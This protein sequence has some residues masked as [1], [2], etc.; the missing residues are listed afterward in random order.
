M[1]WN[2]TNTDISE[3]QRYE[4][5]TYHI[6]RE[7]RGNPNIM[8]MRQYDLLNKHLKINRNNLIKKHYMDSS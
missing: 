8:S 5:F 6:E 4:R 3:P 2:V 1:D 7:S